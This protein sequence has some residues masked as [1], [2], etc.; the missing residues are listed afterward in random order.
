MVIS[1]KY[2]S[3]SELDGI[4]VEQILQCGPK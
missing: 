3:M 1:R 4:W 2:S